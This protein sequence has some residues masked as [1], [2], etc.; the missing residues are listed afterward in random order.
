MDFS[1][2][3]RKRKIGGQLLY[4]EYNGVLCNGSTLYPWAH[5]ALELRKS[6]VK[7]YRRN[8]WGAQKYDQKCVGIKDYPN[9]SGPLLAEKIV[10]SGS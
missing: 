1:L 4:Y 6:Y 10:Q 8:E 7:S 2:N 9:P 5:C 3:E